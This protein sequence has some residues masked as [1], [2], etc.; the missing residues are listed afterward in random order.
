MRRRRGLHERTITIIVSIYV[1]ISYTLSSAAQQSFS[2]QISLS[3]EDFQ[4]VLRSNIDNE[5]DKISDEKVSTA[6]ETTNIHVKSRTLMRRRSSIQRGVKEEPSK[7]KQ[8]DHVHTYTQEDIW[9]NIVQHAWKVADTTKR[10]EG[11]NLARTSYADTTLPIPFLVCGHE[12]H[13]VIVDFN[14]IAASFHTLEEEALLISSSN[15]RT[16]LI[17]STQSTQ[18]R[19]V[20]DSFEG[21]LIAIP[22]P[23]VTKIHSG[24]I[25]EVLSK[26]WSVPFRQESETTKSNATALM[27]HWER[28]I[29]V[30]FA[31]NIGGMKE[32]SDLLDVVNI[33]MN[34]LQDLGE[35]GWYQKMDED[36]KQK[37]SLD[38]STIDIP[39]LS[40]LFS[41]TAITNATPENPRI[42]FWRDVFKNGIESSHVCSSMFS[43]LFVKASNGHYSFE[44]VLNPRDG[45]P[46]Q[47]YESSAS[48]PNCV[49]S[50]IAALSVHPY[51]L[52]VKANFPTYH[53]WNVAQLIDS[54]K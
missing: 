12:E 1:V 52:S 5:L 4:T 8:S 17:L 32:E 45:P 35:V 7:T 46:S 27:N 24:T 41:L 22:L 54:A 18:A 37:Y 20:I 42:R 31:P 25:D 14:D 49:A 9:G 19:E 15:E 51:V 21:S 6:Q 36:E 16:C 23:D 26:G 39:S 40:D 50:L 28:V 10:D 43:T 47:E 48:N 13:S 44:L 34:D 11:D 29:V 2:A 38:E 3:L 53:G 30:D 33:I